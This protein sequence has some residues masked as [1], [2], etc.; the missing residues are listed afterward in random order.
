MEDTLSMCTF[1]AHFMTSWAVLPQCVILPHSS[2]ITTP[3][4]MVCQTLPAA[5]FVEA[6]AF[7][8][9]AVAW[10]AWVASAV[11]ATVAR[12]AALR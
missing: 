3:S 1:L 12:T 9:G 2:S 6:P 8:G 10:V 11:E 5:A 4:R 7:G